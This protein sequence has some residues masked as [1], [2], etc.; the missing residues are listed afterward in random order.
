MSPAAVPHKPRV[1]SLYP[2]EPSVIEYGSQ[3]F[4]LT[5][6]GDPD[7]KNWREEAEAVMVRSNVIDADDVAK[8][9]PGLK[10]V[11][12]HGVG[13]D[14]LA[15]K[16]IRSKGVIIMNT[17][18]VNATAVAELA[19]AL[20]M[21]LARNIP[22]IDRRIRSGAT[23]DKNAEGAVGIQLT[24]RTFG[25]VGGGNIGYTLGKMLYGAFGA[26][27]YLYDPVLSPT[28]AQKWADLLPSSKLI[29]VD[30]VD[31]MMPHIDVLSLHVPLIE[32]TRGII[33]EKQLKAMK[34]T[35]I[36]VNTARG[37]VVDE[38]ALLKALKEKWISA[39][40]I[41]AYAIEPPHVD[42]YS[43]LIAQERVVSLPHIGA[44]SLDV[45]RITAIAVLDHLKD[46]FA[47]NPRD[48]VT[49]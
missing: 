43:E 35:A 31:D 18:G 28:M 44:A 19:L 26:Q 30:N 42:N 21:T 24:G 7:W 39:A 17:A 15:A 9:G 14:Q 49:V 10:F 48:I 4:D 25:I 45:I 38:A 36:V 22:A 37:G 23:V 27:I 3:F 5:V 40:G 8:F 1:F 6:P 11:G 34:P 46:A 2:L 47:G 29:R 41:D 32:S 12:K 13:I 20:T 33:G 16:E